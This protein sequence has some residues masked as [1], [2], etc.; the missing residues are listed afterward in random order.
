MGTR[1]QSGR[2]E[3]PQ[4]VATRLAEADWVI[5]TDETGLGAW[6]GDL[7]VVMVAI[8]RGWTPSVP[9]G[10]SKK[11]SPA[12]RERAYEALVADPRIMH[13]VHTSGP[14]YVDKVGVYRLLV[15][16]HTSAVRQGVVAVNV[17]HGAGH[18]ILAIVDGNLPID[19][20]T[21]I[22]KADA[23]VPAVSAASIIA[24]VTRDREMAKMATIYPGYGFEK[25]MGYGTPEHEA[26]L[27]KL[28]VSEIHRRSYGPIARLL[29]KASENVGLWE[30]FG[31][32]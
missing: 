9:I 6:A 2:S 14:R 8:P 29:E 22:P 25:H 21:S 7:C 17:K 1:D 31:D 4:E 19:G 11:L 18:R 24:K 28:G 30:Q 16:L 15:M 20:A 23:L 12:A 3:V 5:G 13:A 26:A 10:D 27:E 32:E